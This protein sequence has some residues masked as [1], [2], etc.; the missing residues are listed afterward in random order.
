V[1]LKDVDVGVKILG[2]LAAF[3]L[4]MAMLSNRDPD[5]DAWGGGGTAGASASS[6]DADPAPP[7]DDPWSAAAPEDGGAL[8]VCDGTAPFSVDGGTIR[9][10][11][12]GP[13]TPFSSAACLLDARTG[14]DQAVRV[15]QEA[16]VTCNDQ[17][18]AIDGGYG[19]ETR[20]AVRGVQT[21]HGI[22]VDG[23]YGPETQA[24]MGWPI[25]SGDGER[26]CGA[27]PGSG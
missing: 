8:P 26:S 12:H 2:G 7:S 10:P 11:V 16:L 17:P 24:A 4:L 3:A 22:R 27:V 9:L 23:I 18:V 21:R 14:G 6:A 5:N 13:V 20:R 15:L 1:A 25:V 19:P